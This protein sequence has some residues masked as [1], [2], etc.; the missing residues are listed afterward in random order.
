ME[1]MEGTKAGD[2]NGIMLLQFFF[3][4]EQKRITLVLAL[5]GER[6]GSIV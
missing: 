2:G 5:R 4:A 1:R 6:N 3:C